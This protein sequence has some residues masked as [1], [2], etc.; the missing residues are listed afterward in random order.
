MTTLHVQ[1][2][3]ERKRCCGPEGCGQVWVTDGDVARF[4][5]GE[6]CM[7]WRLAER[8]HDQSQ[9]GYCGLAGDGR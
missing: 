5:I 8:V 6:R 7:A 1:E 3:A 9:R 4:C 2:A